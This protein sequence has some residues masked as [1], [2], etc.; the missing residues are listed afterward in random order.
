M[1]EPLVATE[2]RKSFAGSP[3]PVLNGVSLRVAE[4]EFVAVM[5]P[6]G[7]GKSTLLYALAGLEPVDAG[8]VKLNGTDLADLSENDLA[9]LRRYQMGFVFQQPTMLHELSILENIVLT[10]ALDAVPPHAERMARARMLMEQAGIWDLRDRFP[11]QVSGGQLQRAGICRALLRKP[12]IVFADE[13]TGALNAGM[14]AAVLDLLVGFNRAGSAILLVTHDANVAARAGRVLLMTDGRIVEE[15]VPG[16]D[17]PFVQL[18][19]RLLAHG[20]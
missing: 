1:M 18:Q 9:D 10:G 5:G 12:A 13:P 8:S 15:V 7:S 20:I 17:Q 19:E 3:V 6:S 4:G 11:S 2:L 14:A 16:S